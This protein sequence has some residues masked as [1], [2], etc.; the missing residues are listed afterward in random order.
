M[1]SL[2]EIQKKLNGIN[3]S[4]KILAV[5]KFQPAEKIRGLYQQGQRLFGE[6][7][8]QEAL[9]KQRALSD[10]QIQWHDIGRLQKNKV[11][12]VLGHFSLIHSVDA[13]ELAQAIDQKAKQQ[14]IQ[15]AILLQLN[16]ANE[17]S[18][19]GFSEENL[20]DST[21]LLD[22]MAGLKNIEIHGLMTMPPLAED[23][24]Q[25]RPYFQRLRKLKDQLQKRWPTLTELSMGTSSDYLVAAE[26]GATMVRLGTM[27]FGERPH[28]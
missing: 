12:L 2:T 18:K 4:T 5:S 26:E 23:P 8:V 1:Q 28:Q 15:Q 10:L 24:K 14:N 21:A 6:N 11:K 20:L 19:G 22:T 17:Q 25:S 27:L 13:L 9:E 16:L 7:Y 3:P